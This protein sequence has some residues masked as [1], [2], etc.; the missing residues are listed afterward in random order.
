MDSNVEREITKLSLVNQQMAPDSDRVG[1][2]GASHTFSLKCLF[3][4]GRLFKRHLL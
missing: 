4:T 2:T 3:L 1:Q